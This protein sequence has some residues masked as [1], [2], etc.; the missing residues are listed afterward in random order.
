MSRY[1]PKSLIAAGFAVVIC[2]VIYPGGLL[3]PLAS[4]CF[5]SRPTEA[6]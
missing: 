6:S 5:L 3:W 2:C 1:L 4:S